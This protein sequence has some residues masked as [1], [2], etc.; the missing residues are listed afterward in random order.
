[1]EDKSMTNKERAKKAIEFV[2]DYEIKQG[3]N[4]E[5]VSTNKEHSGYDVKSDDR[6]IEVKGVGE[7]WKTYTWQSLYKT[8]VECLN[9]NPNSFYLYIVKF[10]NKE[11]DEVVGFYIIPGVDLKSK[12]RIEIENYGLR[13]ISENTLKEFLRLQK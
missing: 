11:S 6:M 13:P 5:D 9:N 1:M 3:R 2:L 10:R 7:S 4:P 12:F 8:E